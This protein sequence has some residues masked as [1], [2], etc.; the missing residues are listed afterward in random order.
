MQFSKISGTLTW[1]RGTIVLRKGQTI[2]DDHPLIVERPDLFT[3]E[4]PGAEIRQGPPAVRIETAMQRPG[5]TRGE[6]RA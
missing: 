4:D 2:E 3:D 6:K 5:E 1:S